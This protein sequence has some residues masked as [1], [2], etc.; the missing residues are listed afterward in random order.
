LHLT[1]ID[2]FGILQQ[3]VGKRTFAVINMGNDAKIADVFHTL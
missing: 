3:A 1:L 2:S